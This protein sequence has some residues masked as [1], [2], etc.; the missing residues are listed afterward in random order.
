MSDATDFI[1]ATPDPGYVQIAAGVIRGLL[2][3]A[4]GVGF[5][6]AL[7]VN[8]SQVQMAATAAVMTGTLIWSAWQKFSAARKLHQAAL[9]SASKRKP[10]EPAT[11]PPPP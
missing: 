2:Q 9:A 10:V 1:P 11:Q 3:I 8:G 7:T 5:T 4:S 6:W